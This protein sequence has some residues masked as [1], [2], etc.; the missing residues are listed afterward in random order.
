M[1]LRNLTQV[2]RDARAAIS[3]AQIAKANKP[4]VAIP[5]NITNCQLRSWADSM[6]DHN[7]NFHST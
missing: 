3:G 7:Y 6:N 1:G 5:E 4:G 2:D